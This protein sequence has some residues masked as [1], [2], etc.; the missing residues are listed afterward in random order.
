VT[1]IHKEYVLLGLLIDF[2]IEPA[3]RL[4]G[5]NLYE[6][7]ANIGLVNVSYGMLKACLSAEDCREL[8][9][10]G[11]A[12]L[13]QRTL[14]AYRRFFQAVTDL[15][16]ANPQLDPT[17]GLFLTADYR[18]GGFRRVGELPERITD[19]GTYGLMH[20][21]G[22]WKAVNGDG[23]LRLIHDRSS[24]LKREQNVWET[25]L[26]PGVQPAIVGQ[27]RRTIQFPLNV[28]EIQ[29]AESTDH[30]PLQIADLLAGAAATYFRNRYNFEPSYRPE[31][32]ASLHDARVL[33]LASNVVWP[34]MAVTP[35]QLGT[36]GAVIADSADFI[37]K[38]LASSAK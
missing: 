16:A 22:H 2:W 5:I 21:V 29:L 9:A 7:G 17:L 13:R 19:L 8:L 6:R 35:E 38:V 11:Q 33:D 25:I 1:L 24:A 20:T 26:N 15:I 31:Y 3:L 18:L 14:A 12:L 10:N 36:T 34:S 4:D 28:G 27:D 23:Q 37:A 32:A 30:A